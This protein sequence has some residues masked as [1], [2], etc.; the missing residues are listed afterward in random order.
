M[1]TADRLLFAGVDCG[2]RTTK[3]VVWDKAAMQVAWS[4]YTA[5][6][7]RPDKSAR[8]LLGQ[9]EAALGVAATDFKS[10]VATGYGRR[11]VPGATR[12]ISEI[13]CHARGVAHL[14]PDVRCIIDIGGQDSK[15]ICLDAAGRVVDFAMNDRCAAGTG[16]FLEVLAHILESTVD[17]LGDMSARA[18]RPIEI[19]ATCVV[20]AES[21]IVGLLATGAEAP[22]I[23]AGVHRA[24]ARR[25]AQMAA[26]LPVVSP[27]VFTGGVA[28]NEG[29]RIA[30]AQSFELPVAVAPWQPVLT[31]ALGAALLVS[32]REA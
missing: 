7:V 1:C 19:N 15:V 17:R 2:S 29:V 25:I 31:G 30:L 13:S 5:T 11:I 14:A 24:V 20:F 22:D 16:R 12:V 23:V 6:G 18:T 10:V 28:A 27:I 8:E 3:L 32:E 9:A 4:G 26:G 21:E